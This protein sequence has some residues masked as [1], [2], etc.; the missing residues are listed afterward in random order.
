MTGLPDPAPFFSVIIP[1]GRGVDAS[2]TIRAVLAMPGASREV[3]VAGSDDPAI[4]A[5]RFL[6]IDD[7][8]PARRRNEAAREA[9]GV[10]LAFIDDDA[11]PREDWLTRAA[12]LF[13]RTDLVAAGGVDPGAPDAPLGERISDTLLAAPLIGSGVAAHE[14][15]RRP[16]PVRRA[17]D[18]ALVNLFVRRSDFWS[19]GGLDE[20]IG[21]I[22]EDSALVERLIARGPVR[23]DPALV[24]HHRRRRFPVPFLRQR[25]RY[26]RK[27]GM[28]L[29]SGSRRLSPAIL[30]LLAAPLILAAAFV[31][32]PTAGNILLTL[33]AL[34]TIAAG[35]VV[36]ALPFP[37]W[38]LF[39]LLFLAHHA[40]Y[41]LGLVVGIIERLVLRRP[42]PGS[43]AASGEN[44]P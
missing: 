10:V 41:W 30:A 26:R 36:S 5:V 31:L 19:V 43:P 1:A 21:Y 17:H 24:V 9:R 22:G 42:V 29:A 37:I 20:S 4:D 32:S 40:I 6:E 2:E 14:R 3:I 15:R 35:G 11:V 13:A 18:V 28:M 25:F 23:F 44:G 34:L 27:L 16:F 39:P 7:A 33:Y 8:N 12:E 38:P